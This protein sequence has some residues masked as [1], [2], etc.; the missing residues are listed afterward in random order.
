V[1]KLKEKL[2]SEE[3]KETKENIINTLVNNFP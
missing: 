2:S 3:I 1:E